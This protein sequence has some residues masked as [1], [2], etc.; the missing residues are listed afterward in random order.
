MGDMR[1]SEPRSNKTIMTEQITDFAQSEVEVIR[2]LLY[3]QTPEEHRV[4]VE[5]EQWFTE[6]GERPAFR[7]AESRLGDGLQFLILDVWPYLYRLNPEAF[8]KAV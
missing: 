3:E 4:E 1:H 8:E 6:L 5:E 2:Y 7:L